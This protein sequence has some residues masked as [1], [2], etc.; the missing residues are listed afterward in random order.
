V[1][2]TARAFDAGQGA[3]QHGLNGRFREGTAVLV[4]EA[5]S[6][7]AARRSSFLI[8]RARWSRSALRRR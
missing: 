3:I 6:A 8:G 2:I 5:V 1:K 7:S 4:Q